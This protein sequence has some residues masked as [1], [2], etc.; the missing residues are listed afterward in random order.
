MTP[1]TDFENFAKFFKNLAAKKKRSSK[2]LSRDA[3]DNDKQKHLQEDH[4][5][6]SVPRDLSRTDAR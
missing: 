4:S 6:L 1:K 5:W 3:R 2:D